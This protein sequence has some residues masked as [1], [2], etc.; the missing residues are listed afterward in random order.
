MD[1]PD[2]QSLTFEQQVA[3]YDA[4]PA[5]APPPGVVP[6]YDHPDARNDVT[7][8][9]LVVSLFLTTLLYSIRLYSRIFIVKKL[10]LEDY[11]GALAFVAYVG[12]IA[13]VSLEVRTGGFLAHQWDVRLGRLVELLKLAQ[14]Q[15]TLYNLSIGFSKVAILLEWTHLFVPYPDRN[16]FFWIC[17]VLIWVNVG[18]YTAVTIV[19]HAQCKPY[20]K[21]WYTFV[22]GHCADT[23]IVDTFVPAFNFA[24]DL[25]ILIFP[26]RTIWK[27]QLPRKRKVA[28]SA[29]FSSGILATAF[30]GARVSV[31][32]R[33]LT[34]QD[35]LWLGSQSVL[36]GLAE[37][38]FAFMVFCFPAVP[39]SI[40]ESHVSDF[41]RYVWSRVRSTTTLSR[42]PSKES[43]LA[44]SSD[45]TPLTDKTP[46]PPDAV[47]TIHEKR[48]AILRDGPRSAPS[49]SS[50]VRH[51]HS[52]DAADLELG[53]LRTTELRTSVETGS[54]A[55]DDQPIKRQHPWL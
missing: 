24:I 48:S 55:A 27:L 2:F 7:I 53:V 34:D 41:P 30:A 1:D 32:V 22:E 50:L 25:T 13:V 21:I 8:T 28:V 39:K 9:V 19:Q 14:A 51:K 11:V 10:R 46:L 20:I 44:N 23:R 52:S 36:F 49:K 43:N 3:I 38:T 42:K 16:T 15:T 31:S 45:S 17:H 18:L 26:Q 12:L 6:D 37:M 54:L 40:H 4:T 47:K 33:A 5:L 29:I 35:F